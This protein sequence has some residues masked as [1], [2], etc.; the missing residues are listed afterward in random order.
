MQTHTHNSAGCMH[1]HAH[2]H[3]RSCSVWRTAG[4]DTKRSNDK[5]QGTK[6][7]EN[8]HLSHLLVNTKLMRVMLSTEIANTVVGFFSLCM[9]PRVPL[10]LP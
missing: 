10:L 5:K 3:A 7:E 8:D 6:E 9:F 1:A 4:G 2:A